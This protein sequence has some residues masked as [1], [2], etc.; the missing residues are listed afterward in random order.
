MPVELALIFDMDG[1][2]VDNYSYHQKA[3]ATFCNRYGLSIDDS[4]RTGVFGGT[5]K[6]H[7]E[8]FF[9]RQ[10]TIEEVSRLEQE[11]EKIYRDIYWQEINAV[12][13][14]QEFLQMPGV[15]NLPKAVATS[16][17]PINVEFVMQHTGLK[18]QFQFILDSTDISKGKPDPEIYIKACEL[19]KLKPEQC[20]VFEDSV[21]GILAAK[22]AG[23]R[24]VGLTTTHNANELPEVN[25]VIPDFR[26]LDVVKIK[27]LIKFE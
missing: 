14:L 18:G 21:N 26:E 15:K 25:M 9:R 5:N 17:P 3:W 13:G 10:M 7:L 8:A 22:N 24:V 2:I 6:D 23:C 4:F 11:K 27:N 19:F 12:N 20:V 16:S 1:V